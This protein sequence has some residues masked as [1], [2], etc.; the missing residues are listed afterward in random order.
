MELS[1]ERAFTSC[2]AA[3]MKQ[4]YPDLKNIFGEN[5]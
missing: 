2:N 5:I 4:K 3:K 1:L